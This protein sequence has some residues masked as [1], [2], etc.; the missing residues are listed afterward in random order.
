MDREIPKDLSFPK[1]RFK[2]VKE[3]KKLDE[4]GPPPD[5]DFFYF[6]YPGHLFY[7]ERLKI[8]TYCPFDFTTFPFDTHQCN[9]TFGL[10]SSHYGDY[11]LLLTNITHENISTMEEGKVVKLEKIFVDSAFSPVPFSITLTATHPNTEKEYGYLFSFS[12]IQWQQK[13]SVPDKYYE[14][15]VTLEWHNIP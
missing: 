3:V 6:V 10:S 15:G 11:K 2:N 12:G 5:N 9:L 1:L 7:V 13:I 14:N 4:F 8:T